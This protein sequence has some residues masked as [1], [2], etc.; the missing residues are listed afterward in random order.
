MTNLY[1]FSN[2]ASSLLASSITNTAT[3]VTIATGTGSE[4]PTPGAGQVAMATLEDT[5]GN[6]EIVQITARSGDSFTVV[7]G[8]EGTT[9]AAFASGS[10]FEMRITAGILGT[11]LQKAGSDTLSGTT[12]LSGILAVGSGG[13]I[14]GGGSGGEISGMAL[15]SQPG[16]TS[17]QILIPISSPPTIGGSVILTS[18]NLLSNL[19]AGAGAVLTNMIVFWH[20]SSGAIPTGYALCD[21]T[22]G[23]PDLRDQFIVGGGGSLAATG[24]YASTTGSTSAGTPVV[25]GGTIVAANLPQHYHSSVIYGGGAGQVVG[26]KGTGAGGN[27]FTGGSGAGVAINW[28]TDNGYSTGGVALSATPTPLSFSG[29]AL[30]GHTHSVAAPPYTAVFAIMKT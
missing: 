16:D 18:A 1:V 23:T 6:I 12:N 10:R 26:P 11:Y 19:P 3:T 27:Y 15:R 7:R 25:S 24:T 21:G 5:S 30:A 2:N 28:N 29:T 9:A 22:A 8:A 13:G 14:H 4:F 17:N 20:G